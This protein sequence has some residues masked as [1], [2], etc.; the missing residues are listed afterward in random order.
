M[1]LT[2]WHLTPEYIVDNWTDEKFALM[3]HALIERYERQSSGQADG[4]TN[5]LGANAAV[6]PGIE[7]VDARKS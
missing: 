4:V 5:A 2:E 6:L 3:T 7:Y 1:L